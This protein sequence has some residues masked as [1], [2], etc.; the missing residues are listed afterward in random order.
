M[1]DCISRQ[2]VLTYIEFILTHGMGKKKSFEF[3]K[4]FVEK[5][6]PVTPKQKMGHWEWVQYDSNSAIGNFHCSECNFIPASFNWASKHL[7]YCPNCGAKM[8]EV[9]E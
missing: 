2:T 4:K 1:G 9:D 7:N 5:L 8:L 6:P 3:I